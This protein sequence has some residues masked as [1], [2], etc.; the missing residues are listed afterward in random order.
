MNEQLCAWLDDD[1]G[2]SKLAGMLR[3]FIRT[4]GTVEKFA[5]TIL[6][7]SNIYPESEMIRIQNVLERL[8][9]QKD[10]ERQ[11]Y[12]G[13]N[14]LESGET[15]EAILVYQGILAEESDD[16]VG[17]KFYAQIYA[18]LGAAYGRLFLYQEAAKMY[19]RAYQMCGDVNLLKPYL[20]ASYKYMSMPE[21][22]ILLTKNT[23]FARI[24]TQMRKEM[25]EIKGSMQ[26]DL[27]E[28]QIEKWKRQYRR[29]HV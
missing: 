26:I 28:E 27:N 9:S 2:L 6:K 14:L 16:S 22:A 10:V 13:N 11:R 7:F 25:E 18:S 12:K 20:Y 1:L 17:E 29:G 8:K 21:Y 3:D 24:N 5:L 15:E 4:R 19:D 23:M